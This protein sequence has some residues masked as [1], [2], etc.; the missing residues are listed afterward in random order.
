MGHAVGDYSSFGIEQL[1][2]GI[3]LILGAFLVFLSVLLIS[4]YRSRKYLMAKIRREWGTAPERSYD[5]TEYDCISH[6][7]LNRETEEFQIDDITWNDLDMDRMFRQMNYTRSFIGESYLYYQLRTPRMEPEPLEEFERLVTYFQEHESEREEMEYFFARIGKTGR[8]SVFDY[9]YNLADV[10]SGSNLVHF[11]M[12]LFILLS[13]CVLLINPQPGILL[14]IAA[15]CC[16]IGS[17]EHYKKPIR[18]YVLSCGAAEKVLQATE[19]LGHRNLGGFGE[20]L[21]EISSAASGFRKMRW[22]MT[23]LMAGEQQ[24]GG[25]EQSLL[26]YLNNCFHIDLILFQTVVKEISRKIPEFEYLVEHIG[27]IEAAIA[28][29]SF[30]TLHPNYAVPELHMEGKVMYQAEDMVH[31][32]IG[33]P[34][35]NS[36]C[37]EK[38]VL[39]TGSN[40]SG[41]STFLKTVAVN[42]LLAQTVHTVTADSWKGRY[43]R[44]YSSMALRDDLLAEESYY[45]VEIRSLKRILDRM[46]G[47]IPILC[48]IDEVLRGTN[49]V[50]RIA[51][52]SQILKSMAKKNLLCFAATHDIELTWLLEQYFEN[53]HFEEQITEDSIQFD[54]RLKD[55]RA[56]TRNAIRLLHLMGYRDDII[57]DA[58]ILAEELAGQY[59]F[60]DTGRKKQ[61]SICNKRKTEQFPRKS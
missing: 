49:T 30:R 35:P 54:Y 2:V 36:I 37:T 12:A 56:V 26:I 6:Y 47:E 27:R 20:E 28:V 43:F 51:A 11:G 42:A 40:A 38:S 53:Y 61:N 58:E 16:S 22:S 15:M 57:R 60:T 8:S 34:V 14:L 31:P 44:I 50:E 32:L 4:R 19:E 29:A 52:S 39:L 59:L 17:Y 46:E 1:A 33:D 3:L 10:D 7:Y 41:K 48:C 9:I 45:I 21:K 5:P 55:G 13:V 18:P 23:M 24:G 25:L